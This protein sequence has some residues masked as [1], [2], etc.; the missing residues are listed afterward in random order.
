MTL[1][2][3]FSD[4]NKTHNIAAKWEAGTVYINNYNGTSAAVPF[5]GYKQS[6]YGRD[7]GKTAIEHYTQPKKRATT[8]IC[9][10]VQIG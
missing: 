1:N 2:L 8:D 4:L 5:G 6:G 7:N 3:C 9:G 10:R